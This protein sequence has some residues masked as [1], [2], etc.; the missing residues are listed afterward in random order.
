[1]PKPEKDK[2]PVTLV[3]GARRGAGR[4]HAAFRA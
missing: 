3:R 2:I 4:G 1:M